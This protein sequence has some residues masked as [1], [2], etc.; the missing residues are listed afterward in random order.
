VHAT[1]QCGVIEVTA[2]IQLNEIERTNPEEA[3]Q[4]RK[5]WNGLRDN[6]VAY[7][8]AMTPAKTDSKLTENVLQAFDDL[9]GQEY[10][11]Y[12]PAHAK[13][14]LVTGRFTPSAQAAAFTKA[15]HAVHPHTPVTVRF[16]DTTGVPNIPDTDP[17][18]AP[19]GMAIRFH[20]AEHVHTDIIAH[21]VNAFPVRTPDEFLEFLHAVHASGPGTPHPM[22]IESFLATHPAALAFVQAPKPLPASFFK[23]S[24][25]AI[26]AYRF[27]NAGGVSRYG[28][29][30]IIP[31]G[32]G[33]YLGADAAARTTADFLFD[34]IAA[35]LGNGPVKMRIMVQVAAQN[36]VTNDATVQWPADRSMLEFGVVEM[37][38]VL[39][40]NEA[41]QR[42]IIFDPIPRVDGIEPSDDPLLN[43]RA[44]LYLMSGR[45]RRAHG[46]K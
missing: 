28:R 11:G 2:F 22:P 42:H 13:G 18:A 16:S 25:F 1:G 30:R 17:N 3:E 21:S 37:M 7:S 38:S 20:L 19:R 14:V 6:F 45:R 44:D 33:E 31:D 41:E 40:N 15:P 5:S 26:S 39:P 43:F 23:D 8:K 34:D 24:F 35:K 9:N 27:T 32:A 12:R 46:P 36:D 29:Y 4:N 10:R